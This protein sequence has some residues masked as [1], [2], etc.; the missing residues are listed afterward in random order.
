TLVGIFLSS[1][2]G[3]P[4]FI[5]DEIHARYTRLPAELCGLLPSVC[6]LEHWQATPD[7]GWRLWLRGREPT[8]TSELELTTRA[9]E[10]ERLQ[11]RATRLLVGG[12]CLGI[13]GTLSVIG[14]TAGRTQRQ[15]VGAIEPAHGALLDR[16]LGHAARFAQDLLRAGRLHDLCEVE[17]FLQ[18]LATVALA[19]QSGRSPAAGLACEQPA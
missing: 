16:L 14:P 1:A 19:S 2:E 3:E 5:S 6:S 10:T 18:G 4:L 7:S 13:A 8:F 9:G 11:Q 15:H 12:R 17:D